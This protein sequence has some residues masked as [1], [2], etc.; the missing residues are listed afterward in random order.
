MNELG[1]VRVG[2]KKAYKIRKQEEKEAEQEIK[3]FK[4]P[5]CVGH[6]YEEEVDDNPEV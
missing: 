5:P 3:K 6:A 2:G 1:A 4:V